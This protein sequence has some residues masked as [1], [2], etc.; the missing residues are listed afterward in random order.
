MACREKALL[1]SCVTVGIV[2]AAAL[3]IPAPLLM[4][5][6]LISPTCVKSGLAS[7]WPQLFTRKLK[8][9]D[10]GFATFLFDQLQVPDWPVQGG[11][12]GSR[13]PVCATS[14]QQLRQQALQALQDLCPGTELATVPALPSKTLPGQ[15]TRVT[16]HGML[17]L[18]SRPPAS[19]IPHSSH[20]MLPVAEQ[21][22]GLGWASSTKPSV[23]VTVGGN[24]L[25]GTLSSV[26]IQA[27]QYLEGMWSISRVNNFLPQP[28]PTHGPIV[29]AD[30][31]AP[32]SDTTATSVSI[33]TSR[34][35]SPVQ[36]GPAVTLSSTQPTSNTTSFFI[37]CHNENRQ[38]CKTC[39][40]FMHCSV[41]VQPSEQGAQ[42][43]V[44]VNQARID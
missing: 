37:S 4:G 8:N 6:L 12:E 15:P 33:N 20:S 17:T 7:C 44:D 41:T 13:C 2:A 21:R 14:M 22:R 23:Q 31:P 11:H 34:Q 25:S 26:T 18:S 35:R 43:T 29:E 28:S 30:Q 5:K 39:A 19:K 3:V 1:S 27:Q 9:N 32:L 38:M 24:A 42:L 10:P 16:T 40:R 36:F